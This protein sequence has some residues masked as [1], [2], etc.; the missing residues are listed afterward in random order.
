MTKREH[1]YRWLVNQ[2]DWLYLRE[3]PH[4]RFKMTK[5]TCSSAL[6]DMCKLGRAEYRVVVLK[7]YRAIPNVVIKKG[8][9]PP[10]ELK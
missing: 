6:A 8:P 10:K 2:R 1:L 3:I 7:Q 5:E 9:K 4:E